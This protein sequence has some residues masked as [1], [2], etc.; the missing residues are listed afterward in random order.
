MNQSGFHGM[1]AKGFERFSDVKLRGD[2]TRTDPDISISAWL[3]FL[4]TR[5]KGT[6][7]WG[8]QQEQ[9]MQQQHK[10]N[11]NQQPTT[12]N[13]QPT[14]TTTTTTATT[15]TTNHRNKNQQQPNTD[16]PAT[17]AIVFQATLVVT[18]W[19]LSP[20]LRWKSFPQLLPWLWCISVTHLCTEIFFCWPFLPP[21]SGWG[22]GSWVF[23]FHTFAARKDL[24]TYWGFILGV[25]FLKHRDTAVNMKPG[26]D[27]SANSSMV[28]QICWRLPKTYNSL[29]I[30]FHLLKWTQFNLST[31]LSLV[32]VFLT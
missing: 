27:V 24:V 9:E 10:T 4:M 8:Q 18:W 15:T 13:Q 25:S 12:N 20:C 32:T 28:C 6:G 11:N 29:Y 5:K 3:W 26:L 31:L 16:I 14:T 1:S 23:L 7:T 30:C 19:H 21:F 17:A 22:V 2:S